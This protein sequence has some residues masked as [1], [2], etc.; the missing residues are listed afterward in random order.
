MNEIVK[1]SEVYHK[2][3]NTKHIVE[4]IESFDNVTLVFT[5]DS[6]CFPIKEVLNTN[7]VHLR[8]CN[9]F[10]SWIF[11]KPQILK[12]DTEEHEELERLLT[13]D[14]DCKK[15]EEDFDRQ[16]NELSKKSLGSTSS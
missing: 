7:P 15:I 16:I 2:V 10:R 3:S 12:E 4:S 9:V 6:K 13:M 5:E 14:Y 8:L 1:G 11:G